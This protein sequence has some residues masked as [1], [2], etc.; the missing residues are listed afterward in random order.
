MI[1]SFK[2]GD[3][4]R[5]KS[6]GPKMTVYGVEGSRVYCVWFEG[7]KKIEDTFEMDTLKDGNVKPS[8]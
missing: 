5:L 7:S 6:G 8:L 4:V 1:V 2:M 3:V